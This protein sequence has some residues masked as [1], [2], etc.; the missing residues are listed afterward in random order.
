[1]SAYR[2]ASLGYMMLNLEKS[3][4]KGVSYII[5]NVLSNVLEKEG[6]PIKQVNLWELRDL[7]KKIDSRITYQWL[8]NFER[9]KS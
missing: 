8:V 2:V 3:L 7:L 6:I 9:Q 5:P 4:F 1:M